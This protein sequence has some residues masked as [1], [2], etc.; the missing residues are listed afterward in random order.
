MSIKLLYLP[1]V[2]VLKHEFLNERHV[3]TAQSEIPNR[4]C[5]SCGSGDTNIMGITRQDYNDVPHSGDFECVKIQFMRKRLRCKNCDK[6]NFEKLD[7]LSSHGRMTNRT[8]DY[9]MQGVETR[10]KHQVSIEIGVCPATVRNV[11]NKVKA[12]AFLEAG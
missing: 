1:N 7:W 12:L 4:T 10:T 8:V 9:I 11:Y 6:T 5:N 2:I 3:F